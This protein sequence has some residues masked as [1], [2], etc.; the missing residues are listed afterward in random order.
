MTHD[1]WILGAR[2][3]LA[4]YLYAHQADVDEAGKVSVHTCV[5]S[6]CI[7]AR[8]LLECAIE[9]CVKGPAPD[10]RTI[11]KQSKGGLP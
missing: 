4:R 6:M 8:N 11:V 3:T 7:S 1:T 10:P 2:H 9:P 5:C